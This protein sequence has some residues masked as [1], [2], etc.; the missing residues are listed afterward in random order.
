MSIEVR[1]PE[2]IM[3]YKEAII[4]GLSLRELIWGGIAMATSA[5]TYLALHWINID[6]ATYATM[7]VA[8]PSLLIGFIR[9]D[10]RK[11][12]VWLKIKIKCYFS[13]SV[14]GYETDSKAKLLPIEN[15]EFREFMQKEAIEEEKQRLNELNTKQNRSFKEKRG[16]TIA[17]FKEKFKSYRGVKKTTKREYDLIEVTEK[18]IKRKRKAAAKTAAEKGRKFRE[19]KSKE[20]KTA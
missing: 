18:S 8:A 3:D 6:L 2:E 15:E 14:R 16:D 20:E 11:F 12:E 4:G 13:K 19:K 9:P 5:G 10:G 7:A 17:W 1:V